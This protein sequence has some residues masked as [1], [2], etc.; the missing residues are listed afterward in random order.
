MRLKVVKD[1]DLL[2]ETYFSPYNRKK[3]YNDHKADSLYRYLHDD[4]ADE[5]F[6][7]E[8]TEEEYDRLGDWLSKRPVKTSDV[9]SSD[10]FVGYVALD[11]RTGSERIIKYDKQEGMLVVY[12]C[13]PQEQLTISFMKVNRFNNHK[14]YRNLLKRDYEREI[15]PEDDLYNI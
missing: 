11:G 5:L 6:D 2:D 7:P 10:R 1:E 14:R 12:V 9:N 3:H 8:M 15:T 13:T 4:E